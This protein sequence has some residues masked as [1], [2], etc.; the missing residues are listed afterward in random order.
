MTKKTTLLN[1]LSFSIFICFTASAA[2]AQTTRF[3][4][5]GKLTDTGTSSVTYDFE[6]RLCASA[7]SCTTPLAMQQVSNVLLTNGVFTVTLDFG[8]GVFDG[9]DRW[10]EIAVKRPA[11]ATYTTLAPLQPLTSEPYAIRSLSATNADSSTLFGGLTTGDF[12]LNTTTQQTGNFNLSGDGTLGGTLLAGQ[13]GI[14]GAPQSSI[15]LDV[16]GNSAFRT[17]NGLLQIGSPNSETGMSIVNTA[18]SSR[19]DLRFN[20]STLK[21][22]ASAGTGPPSEN[23]GI[24]IN[25]TG[26]V[27]I[28]KIP[29][30]KLD[31]AGNIFTSGFL[32]V[33]N[34]AG[35]TGSLSV[36]NGLN[37]SNGLSVNTGNL[38]VA[39]ATTLNNGLTLTGDAGVS[40]KITTN[41]LRVNSGGFSFATI[42]GTY[43]QD[44]CRDITFGTLGQCGTSLRKYKSNIENFAGG[45]NIINR[46]R[47]V[48]FTWKGTEM[49]DVGFIAEEVFEIEP[50][51]TTTNENGELQGVRYRQINVVLVNAVKQQQGQISQQQKQIEHQQKQIDALMRLVCTNNPAA[52]ICKEN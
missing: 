33:G 18:G 27:G 20:G 5:Q 29:T 43:Q 17:P 22:T 48:S 42:A 31:V 40:G 21:L 49:R 37:V 3:T 2:L 32:S 39:G 7:G 34:G 45:L 8:A 46:L 4:Y 50:L 23:N 14:G 44:I 30:T 15:I 51:L 19:A 9:S 13:V 24:I 52:E 47:P 28:G 1:L 16:T 12:I 36:S 26:N 35:I 25:T 11:Q 38:F 41:S 6:F 10:L